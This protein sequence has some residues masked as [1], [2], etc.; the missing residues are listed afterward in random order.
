MV[1]QDNGQYDLIEV[2]AKSSIR[3]KVD[4]EKVEYKNTGNIDDKFIN[5][6]SFQKWVINKVLKKE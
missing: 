2:K 4:H 6:T 3:K 5:D 1:L